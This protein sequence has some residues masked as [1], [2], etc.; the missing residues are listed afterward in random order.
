MTNE[1]L[2]LAVKE[3]K[4]SVIASLYDE[5]RA[6][7]LTW[8][9][10]KFDLEEETLIDVYQDSIIILYQNIVEGKLLE[11]R[12]KMSSYLFGIGKH[13]I[14]RL[15]RDK[16][17]RTTGLD[18][19]NEI[20]VEPEYLGN[21]DRDDVVYRLQR[22]LEHLAWPCRQL[23]E[24]FYYHNYDMQM[25]ADRMKYKNADTVKAKK[26]RCMKKLREHYK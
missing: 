14:Y 17:E 26:S 10:R 20:V 4:E 5:Y 18:D 15:F 1:E 21:V 24:Y 6:P 9:R 8:A 13:L 22:A 7:F 3:G 25:I 23:I 2:I 11:I 16:N 19:V 12:G